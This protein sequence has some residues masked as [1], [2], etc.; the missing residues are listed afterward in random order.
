M[1][2]RPPP[3]A[4]TRAALALAWLALAGPA[5]AQ[6]ID[7]PGT[8]GRAYLEIRAVVDKATTPDAV[9]PYLSAT[10]R[11][12]VSNLPRVE[13]DGWLARLKR[14]PPAVPRLQAQALAGDRCAL[15]VVARD[16]THVKWSGRV[17]MVREGNAWKLADE[18]W[19]TEMAR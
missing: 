5:L 6:A 9:L 13:R 15:G 17:E 8:P 14:T 18:V 10:Y 2:G 16:A 1:T 19:S 7:A 11:R 4:R 12:V 3:A